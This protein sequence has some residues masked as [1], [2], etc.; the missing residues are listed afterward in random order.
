LVRRIDKSGCGVV[1]LVDFKEA[2]HLPGESLEGG[3][4]LAPV[5][6][7]GASGGRPSV[8]HLTVPPKRMVELRDHGGARA[9]A[10]LASAMDVE[11]KDV[12]GIK[13]KAQAQ[14]SLAAV[15]DSRHIG[16]RT[17][18][19]CWA[20]AIKA[21]AEK[22]LL[23]RNRDRVSLGH[24][25]VSGLKDPSKDK[26]L[27]DT[28]VALEITDTAVTRFGSVGAASKHLAAAIERLLPHPTRFKQ[29]WNTLGKRTE[30]HLFVWQPVAPSAAFV[31]LGMVTSPDDN[32]P[33]LTAVR[34]VPLRWCKP[35]AQPPRLLWDDAGT[36]G[37]RGALWV[38]NSMGL[39]AVGKGAEP[40]KDP[41]YDLKEDRFFLNA[42]DLMAL[43]DETP[44][45]SSHD[46]AQ[47]G[48]E[49]PLP[50]AEFL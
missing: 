35:A 40:P 49:S 30:S 45:G 17:N 44:A 3:Q 2:F 42:D 8:H 27:K 46:A 11:M 38:V 37:K 12:K 9:A 23:T 24:Y 34:C 32:P 33:L 5:A 1:S 50:A 15:W 10:L 43:R 21:G 14:A 6:D 19:S 28:V 25:A 39:L 48:A 20:P 7:D 13:V 18:V 41:Y 36:G 26:E 4:G 47:G 16:A 22:A 29:V 31:A